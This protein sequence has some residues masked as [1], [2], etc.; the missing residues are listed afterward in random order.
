MSYSYL[1]YSLVFV[2]IIL[3]ATISSCTKG[4]EPVPVVQGSGVSEGDGVSVFS[5]VGN[6]SQVEGEGSDVSSASPGA[7]DIVGGDDNED[8]D[9]SIFVVGG[10][11]NEDDDD[12]DVIG[13]GG[14]V[15]VGFDFSSFNDND[16]GATDTVVVPPFQK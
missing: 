12:F 5:R 4:D 8:D 16:R 2:V 13:N 14:G 6:D 10:D 15:I 9:D 11:D 1:R 3:F 7:P